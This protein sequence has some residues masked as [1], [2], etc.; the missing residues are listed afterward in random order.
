MFHL[1]I[2]WNK[3]RYFRV[4]TFPRIVI[5][6]WLKNVK[7]QLCKSSRIYIKETGN[8]SE[9]QAFIE[10]L[11]FVVL[12]AIPFNIARQPRSRYFQ[13]NHYFW[14]PLERQK[15]AVMFGRPQVSRGRYFR[16]CTLFQQIQDETPHDLLLI[17]TT[18]LRLFE[19][20]TWFCFHR[21]KTSTTRIQEQ[22]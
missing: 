8:Y 7:T 16:N 2:V 10:S 13:R 18:F 21:E 4:V 17:A 1:K 20:T 9:R 14:K 5:L 19:K 6:E 22:I 15:S 11:R 3:D 12:F